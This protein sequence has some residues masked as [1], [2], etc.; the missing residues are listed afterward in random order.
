MRRLCR[1]CK[2][3][4]YTIVGVPSGAHDIRA[5]RVGYAPLGRSVMV[6]ASGTV[7]AILPENGEAVYGAGTAFFCSAVAAARMART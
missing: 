7:T 5:R 1:G 6:P 3:G 4:R 2:P